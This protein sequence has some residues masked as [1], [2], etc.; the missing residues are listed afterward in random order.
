[1]EV[2]S[3]ER[4]NFSEADFSLGGARKVDLIKR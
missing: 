4:A 2:K 1:M 3:L